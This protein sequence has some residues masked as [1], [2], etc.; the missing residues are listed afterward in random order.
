MNEAAPAPIMP[1]PPVQNT[2]AS[3]ANASATVP[4]ATAADDLVTSGVL[5]NPVHWGGGLGS[6]VLTSDAFSTGSPAPAS[7][8]ASGLPP[9]SAA[10]APP[11][12]GHAGAAAAA[13]M[14]ASTPAFPVWALQPKKE[15]GARAFLSKYPE[16]D[17]RGT[18]IAVLDSGQ[19][20][21]APHSIHTVYL[22]RAVHIQCPFYHLFV[23]T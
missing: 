22:R 4:S 16:Y 21:L 17:G 13:G 1:P 20:A 8:S 5:G 6:T 23:P 3:A 18:I 19:Y 12:A 10:A 9:A 11:A 15:T 14:A 2:A 7:S